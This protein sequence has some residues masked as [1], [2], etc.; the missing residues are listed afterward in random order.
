MTSFLLSVLGLMHNFH[1]AK[2]KRLLSTTMER[3]KLLTSRREAQLRQLHIDV[4]KLL[5]LGKKEKAQL[6]IGR[7][8]RE[9]RLLSIEVKI[10]EYCDYVS[11]HLNDVAKNDVCPKYLEEPVEGLCLA[12][13]FC[14][15]LP[16][17]QGIREL[18]VL[19]FGKRFVAS[20]QEI[21]ASCHVN[22][23]FSRCL[24]TIETPDHIKRELSERIIAQYNLKQENAL[25]L[26]KQLHKEHEADEKYNDSEFLLDV[27]GFKALS[28][29]PEN[30]NNTLASTNL[31]ANVLHECAAADPI[32]DQEDLTQPGNTYSCASDETHVGE[33]KACTGPLK[34][35]CKLMESQPANGNRAAVFCERATSFSSPPQRPPPPPPLPS[36]PLCRALTL[37]E[38]PC[39]SPPQPLPFRSLS[40]ACSWYIKRS[41][42]YKETP[43]LLPCSSMAQTHYNQDFYG[44]HMHRALP[45]Y[46]DL[47]ANFTALKQH[48]YAH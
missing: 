29:R 35:R 16:E 22:T 33:R 20:A 42:S 47:V 3:V 15:D 21:E 5:Q 26:W 43:L 41:S 10:S 13:S 34:R 6:W 18:F 31:T 27:H 28:S 1:K 11:R 40:T 8:C 25:L 17:L 48:S 37:S 39:R 23:E 36:P 32:V 2:C 45:K 12:A 38:P 44:D 30:V 46:E 7:I 4:A 9:L 14:A 24:C 19:K